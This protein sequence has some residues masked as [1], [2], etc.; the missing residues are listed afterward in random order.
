MRKYVHRVGRTARAGRE[1]TA[2]TLV[3]K[4]EVS[5]AVGAMARTLMRHSTSLGKAFQGD[6]LD[7]QPSSASE[8]DQDQGGSA[9]RAERE[10]RREFHGSH[11]PSMLTSVCTDRSVATKGG[12]H[13]SVD[14]CTFILYGCTGCESRVDI[15]GG[16]VKCHRF[17]AVPSRLGMTLCC[18]ALLYKQVAGTC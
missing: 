9:C 16:A 7:C 4:Q 11:S 2:W 1:G 6:A 5:K 18:A 10:L 14:G 8:E 15:L 3:E 13:E 12:I 17:T